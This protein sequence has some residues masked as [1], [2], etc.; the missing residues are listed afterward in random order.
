[1]AAGRSPSEFAVVSVH[2]A[3]PLPPVRAFSTAVLRSIYR[4]KGSGKM[5]PA[6]AISTE[7]KRLEKKGQKKKRGHGTNVS[8]L[9]VCLLQHA[10]RLEHGTTNRVKALYAKH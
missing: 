3:S 7:E 10:K 8:L 2:A 5:P 6:V 9:P 1:M 4:R